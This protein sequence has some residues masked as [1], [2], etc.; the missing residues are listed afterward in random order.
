[1]PK[2][3]GTSNVRHSYGRA[4]HS[5]ARRLLAGRGLPALPALHG[6]VEAVVSTAA[7]LGLGSAPGSGAGDRGLAITNFR[8]M[9]L[10]KSVAARTPQPS[11]RGDCSP[12]IL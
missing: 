9:E 6:V 2:A 10:M 12:G 4:C 5:C 11:G 1:M 8:A 7:Q 3:E